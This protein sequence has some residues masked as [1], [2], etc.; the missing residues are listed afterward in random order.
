M[1][2][3]GFRTQFKVLC[4]IFLP[5][6]LANRRTYVSNFS[7]TSQNAPPPPPETLYL[8]ELLKVS[9]GNTQSALCFVS[10]LNKDCCTW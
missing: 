4:D 8:L 7:A 1:K 5:L 9:F 6:I 3:E 10:V 2:V